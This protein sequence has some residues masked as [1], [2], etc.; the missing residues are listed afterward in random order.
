MSLAPNLSSLTDPQKDALILS[1]GGQ[2][3]VALAEIA[4]LKA[5]IEALTRPPKTPDNSSQP[6]SSSRKANRRAAGKTRRRRSGPG[7]GRALHDAP[8]R[9]VELYVDNTTPL[10]F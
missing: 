5:Q 7:I 10:G 1:L 3:Q 4:G 8:D 9:T 2:L 6:P